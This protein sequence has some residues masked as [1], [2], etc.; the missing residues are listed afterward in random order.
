VFNYIQ[1]HWIAKQLCGPGAR[2]L[3]ICCG[4]GLLLPLLRYHAKPGLYVGVD[5]EPSNAVFLTKRVTD[6]KPLRDLAGKP[7]ADSPTDE[8]VLEEHYGFPV[9]F[10][11]SNAAE[12]AKPIRD[13]GLGPFDLLVYTSSIEHM[14]PDA[15]AASLHQARSL[16]AEGATLVLTCPNTPEGKDGYDTRY[17]AHVYEWK[18]SE[19]RAALAASGWEPFSEWPVLVEG[20]RRGLQAALAQ[21]GVDKLLAPLSTIPSEWLV[22]VLSP[23]CPPAS[24]SEIGILAKA[25][26][27]T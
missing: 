18:L 22:P 7:P 2:V 5:I 20:G 12:M 26:A 11:H 24:A 25:I 8:Q 4:R 19:L 27:S 15:G 10:V 14:H 16:A 6:G 1:H 23:L 17:K 13:R 9:R 3:D 21:R